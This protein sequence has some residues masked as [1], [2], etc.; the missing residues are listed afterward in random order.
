MND[1]NDQTVVETNAALTA[2]TVSAED[3]NDVAAGSEF[4]PRLSLFSFSNGPFKDGKIAAGHYGFNQ[5]NNIID[6]GT[7]I[8]LIV[9]GIRLKALQIDGDNITAIFN[10]QN[11]EFAKIQAMSGV[12]DSDCLCGPE[13]LVYIPTHKQFC[14]FYM[15]SKTMKREAPNVK[16]FYDQ[17]K[18]ITAKAQLIT[19]GKYKWHGPVIVECSMV[20][21]TP[22][23]DK[24]YIE[25]AKFFGAKDTELA[26]ESA[27]GTNDRPR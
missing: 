17:G 1:T 10:K 12:K 26:P 9:C 18:N 20:L 13:F 27:T 8:Q 16:A 19:K 4:L 11:P 6:C 24:L 7:E 22:D 21:S 3:F 23:H 25:K 14:T 15:A 5:G 2:T